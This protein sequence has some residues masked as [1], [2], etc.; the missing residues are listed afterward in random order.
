MPVLVQRRLMGVDV[1]MPLQQMQTHAQCHQKCGQPK[2]GAHSLTQRNQRNE[3]ASKRRDCEVRSGTC[4]AKVSQAENEEHQTQAVSDAPKHHSGRDVSSEEATRPN[5]KAS[6]MSGDFCPTVV[7]FTLTLK[8]LEAI[9]GAITA[10][11]LRR[12]LLYEPSC[13]TECDAA[14]SSGLRDTVKTSGA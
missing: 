1:L 5:A 4:S 2:I 10:E 11:R 12:N 14:A 9:T 7:A 6:A 13:T 3:R 8:N